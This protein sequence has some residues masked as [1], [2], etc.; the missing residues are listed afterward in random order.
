MKIYV[1][2]HRGEECLFVKTTYDF[3]FKNDLKSIEHARWSQTYKCWYFPYNERSI[4]LLKKFT[5]HY[6]LSAEWHTDSNEIPLKENYPET[7]T[8]KVELSF[9]KK[10][11]FLK[12]TENQKDVD[13]LQGFKYTRWNRKEKHWIIPNFRDNLQQLQSYFGE[14]LSQVTEKEASK[15]TKEKDDDPNTLQI[16]KT[17]RGR[18]KL[19]YRYNRAFAEKIKQM[20]YAVWDADNRWWSIPYHEKL[21]EDFLPVLITYP[22]LPYSALPVVF[23]LPLG[24][25][26]YKPF[27]C[28]PLLFHNK[29]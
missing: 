25:L 12:L 28:L 9:D 3:L 21:L 16:I 20:P 17:P 5:N 13:Y 8:S 15:N 26:S 10:N 1:N 23:F 11:I 18:I 7:E 24:G 14:R 19:I 29:T 27:S 22:S 6:K 4:E 2:V